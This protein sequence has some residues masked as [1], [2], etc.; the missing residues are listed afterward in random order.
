METLAQTLERAHAALTDADYE[1]ALAAVIGAWRRCRTP[2][3]S[4]LVGAISAHVARSL[5]AIDTEL[6]DWQGAWYARARQRRFI[7]IPTLLPMATASPKEDIPRRI[8]Q[9]LDYR[10]DPRVGRLLLDMIEEPPTTASSNFSMWTDV[11]HELPAYVDNTADMRLAARASIRPNASLFWPK[12]ERLIAEVRP[13]LLPP[14]VLDPDDMPALARVQRLIEDLGAGPPPNLESA[15]DDDRETLFTVP[16]SLQAA[17]DHLN[18]NRLP[19]A[20]DA[21]VW[22]WSRHRSPELADAIELL[23]QLALPGQPVLAASSRKAFQRVWMTAGRNPRPAAVGRL[24]QTLREG[25]LAQ[26]EARLDAMFR[27]CPD[28]R[29]AH[30]LKLMVQDH[31]LSARNRLWALVYDLLVYHADSRV[32]SFFRDRQAEIRDR[33]RRHVEGRHSDRT[34]DDFEA[35]CAE[36]T[37]LAAGESER[38]DDI[39]QQ[40]RDLVDAE[41][42][43]DHAA[44]I[45][46]RLV[47]AIVADYQADGPRLVYAD[48]LQQRGD[49]RG[50]FITLD[51]QLSQGK[52]VKGRRD[53]YYKTHR[54]EILGPTARLIG[55]GEQVQR[56]LLHSARVTMLPGALDVPGTQREAMLADVRWAALREC[57]LFGDGEDIR[58]FLASAPLASLHRLEGVTITDFLALA[59]R[60]SAIPLHFVRLSPGGEQAWG[61]LGHLTRVLPKLR[62][63]AVKFEVADARTQRVAPPVAFFQ[64]PL[65]RQLTRLRDGDAAT[66]SV[67]RLDEWLQRMAAASCPV[68]H[69]EAI[70]PHVKADAHLQKDRTYAV[71]LR[72][73]S[74]PAGNEAELYAVSDMLRGLPVGLVARVTV[75][76]ADVDRPEQTVLAYALKHL[77]T[78]IIE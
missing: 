1:R 22:Y 29:V 58:D 45:E 67:P 10:P 18:E 61:E 57:H 8:R 36:F 39:A 24:L 53:K 13:Q 27:W 37:G 70:G 60:P 33:Q 62:E 19:E 15:L 23:S 68:A 5:P 43:S 42:D 63:M 11:F 48:W 66:A 38:L 34:F 51:I 40:L 21:M 30:T 74:I 52:R 44:R 6:E 28:P 78:E 59:R 31:K 17:L 72:I 12:F 25:T 75:E 26:L 14:D 32:L 54:D 73:A 2:S 9:L 41:L 64:S 4:A 35:A 7:D 3:L 20:L 56:G 16:D 69:L 49:P 50:E 77:P 47:A 65:V 55:R 71:H 46:Q 76:F